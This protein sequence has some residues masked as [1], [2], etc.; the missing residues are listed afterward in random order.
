MFEERLKLNKRFAAFAN[1]LFSSSQAVFTIIVGLLMVPFYLR[2]FNISTYGAWL[3][4]GNVIAMIALIE[5][6]IATVATQRLS[7]SYA[8]NEKVRFA[9]IFGSSL[10]LSVGFGI[11]VILVGLCLSPFI[12]SWLN[13]PSEQRHSL[14][15]ALSFST[16]GAGTSFIFYT[17]GAATQAWQRTVAP[18]VIGLF[19]LTANIVAILLGLYAGLGVVALG[20][21][22]FA[23]STIYILGYLVYIAV[24]WQ[25]LEFPRPSAS[26][27]TA[28]EI[29]HE[30]KMLLLAKIAGTVGKYLE[31]PAAAFAV[32]TEAAAILILTGRVLN[33][34]QMF[35]DRVGTAVFAGMAHSFAHFR[36]SADYSVMKEVIVISTVISG[37]GIGF[38]LALSESIINLW[39]GKS[40][41][42]GLNLLLLLSLSSFISSRKDIISTLLVAS[43]Q[44]RR[45]S[46]WLSMEALIRVLFITLL[47][48]MFKVPGIPLAAALASLIT[49]IGLSRVL[50]AIP[51]L[52]P[53]IL[54]LP[55]IRGCVISLLMGLTYMYFATGISNWTEVALHS[56]LFVTAM[57]LANMLD[58]EWSTVLRQTV[59][60]SLK[61]VRLR[62]GTI[63]R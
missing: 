13:A 5:P 8:A 20:L 58:K 27:A 9:N 15:M 43:G 34:V 21:G 41:F 6:G 57:L 4:S 54:Y 31:A 36:E 26:L 42:G 61:A 53:D 50:L 7:A 29:W 10:L 23:L 11:V 32:S 63:E 14:S 39:V 30:A 22:S 62:G 3:A 1:L 25:R 52:P 17:L 28:R 19:A 38:S 56:L 12:P 45:A 47:V 48:I 18:G 59:F 49:A 51:G 16:L 55:G 44:I 24:M 33:A 46:L 60:A 40:A 37:L 2:H 35:A